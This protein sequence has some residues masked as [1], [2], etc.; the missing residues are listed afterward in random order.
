MVLQYVNSHCL[1]VPFITLFC[2]LKIPLYISITIRAFPLL[3]MSH[4]SYMIHARLFD[5]LHMM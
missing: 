1:Y 5:D 3:K 4:I 2:S